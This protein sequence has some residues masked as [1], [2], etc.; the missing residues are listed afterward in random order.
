MGFAMEKF[1]KALYYPHDKTLK[2]K[3]G[4]NL[5]Y[6]SRQIPFTLKQSQLFNAGITVV[7]SAIITTHPTTLKIPRLNRQPTQPHTKRAV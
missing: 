5:S 4:Y 7:L 3:Y 2:I 1:A 6:R